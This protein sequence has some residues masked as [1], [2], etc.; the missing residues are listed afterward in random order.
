MSHGARLG[1]IIGL[2]ILG[3]IIV[4]AVILCI[5]RCRKRP[6]T[7]PPDNQVVYD[8]AYITDAPVNGPYP[9]LYSNE[10]F[11]NGMNGNQPPHNSYQ[12]S[13]PIRNY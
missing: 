13:Y 4:A 5:F 12:Q 8:Q 7:M 2:S 11:G 3:A 9:Q 1:L 10:A 6:G